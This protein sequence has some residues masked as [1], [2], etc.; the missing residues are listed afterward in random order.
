MRKHYEPQIELGATPIEQIVIKEDR[1]D[2]LPGILRGLQW[3]YCTH[4]VFNPIMELLEKKIQADKIKTGRWGMDLWQVFVLGVL[5]NG[6]NADFS[7][8]TDFANN[9]RLIREMMGLV[10]FVKNP[11]FHYQTICDNVNLI[12]EE[13]LKEINHIIAEHGGKLFKK[14]DNAGLEIRTDGY[15]LETNVHFP[16][17]INLL[18]DSARKCLDMIEKLNELELIEGW[19]KHAD[20][21]CGLKSLKMRLERTQH[22]GGKNKEKRLADAVEAYLEKAYNLEEKVFKTL[23]TLNSAIKENASIGL[24]FNLQ[25]YHELLIHHIILVHKR[26][27]DGDVI[28]HKDK[29][30]SIFERHTQWLQKGKSGKP[31]ELGHNILI[32]VDQYRL[33]RDYE[34]LHNKG[35]KEG[36]L[37]V[38]S[39]LTDKC[40]EPILSISTDKGFY[41][42]Q[43]IELIELY[44]PLV[45]IPKPG[46]RNLQETEKENRKEFAKAI[47]KHSGV[48]SV[49]NSLEHHGMNRC[50]NKGLEGYKRCVGFGVLSYNLHQIGNQLLALETE[51][52]ERRS[53]K[54]A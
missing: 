32:S 16:T 34:I 48:E 15:V 7:R 18:W 20:W 39:R 2:E 11:N 45:A 22:S 9:H 19:R 26:L 49:I 38:V 8:L 31:V 21:R 12:D 30:F 29:Y 50:R 41:S 37:S 23:Q 3:I 35:E 17:D 28:E 14:K 53:R 36:I 46:K 54:T 10:G 43:N 6:M 33:I 52:E 27:V 44:I 24:F 51:A 40:S 4:E 5:R 25:D 13:T 42:A 47:K 1:R